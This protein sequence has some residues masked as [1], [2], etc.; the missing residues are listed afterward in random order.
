MSRP[1]VVLASASPRR[2]ELLTQLGVQF[3]VAHPDI[4]ETPCAREAPVAYVRRL[5]VEKAHTVAAAAGSLVIAADTTVDLGGDIL[6]K[7]DDDDEA[8]SMLRRLSGRTHRV[9]TGIAL[10]LGDRTVAETVTSL[11]TFSPLTDEMIEWYVASGE[12]AGKAGAYAIQGAGGVFVERVR[13]SVSN[14]I[15]LPLHTLLRLSTDLDVKLLGAA[16]TH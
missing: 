5:A 7:P 14:I 1:P 16:I 13:G 6:G 15:G 3:T 11:V 2:H 8:R 10:R 12:P 4:D 9:H